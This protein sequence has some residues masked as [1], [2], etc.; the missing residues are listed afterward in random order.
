[1]KYSSLRVTPLLFAFFAVVFAACG[2]PRRLKGCDDPGNLKVRGQETGVDF[3]TNGPRHR[4]RSQACPVFDASTKCKLD[5]T[6]ITSCETN[7]DCA[8]FGINNVCTGPPPD[9]KTACECH[10]TCVNDTDCGEG[11]LCGCNDPFSF[12]L[13]ALC[14]TDADCEEG[15]MCMSA[16]FSCFNDGGFVCQS[17]LDDCL[18]SED[19]PSPSRCLY[20]AEEGHRV[21]TTKCAE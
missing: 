16:D 5:P 1:M 13:K 2:T 8:K 3:C 12:C 9:D 14:W 7:A 21:C 4:V 17:E 6:R 18:I 11:K 10:A 15:H 20:N 19:C